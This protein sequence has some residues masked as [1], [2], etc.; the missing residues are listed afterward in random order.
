M[1][2]GHKYLSLILPSRINE[3]RTRRKTIKM[4]FSLLKNAASAETALKKYAEGSPKIRN[5]ANITQQLR[6][7]NAL[8]RSPL[9]ETYATD[10]ICTGC[11][12][13]KIEVEAASILRLKSSQIRE[14]TSMELNRCS[15]ILLK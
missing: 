7:K 8:N 13:N 11:T 9:A 4:A 10:E 15:N 12:I 3:I 2:K 5:L 6:M 1:I 14:K